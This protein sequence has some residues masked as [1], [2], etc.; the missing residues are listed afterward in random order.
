MST[1]S[2]VMD[3]NINMGFFFGR[4]RFSSWLFIVHKLPNLC[5]VNAGILSFLYYLNRHK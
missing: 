5:N 3:G 1:L 4:L 2:G